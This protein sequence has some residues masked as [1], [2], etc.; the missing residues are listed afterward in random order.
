MTEVLLIIHLFGVILGAG[1]AFASDMMFFSSARDKMFSK[2]EMRFLKIGS[3]MVWTGLIILV[4]SGT[5]L[6]LQ[7]TERYLASSKFL[8]KMTVVAVIFV[9]GIIFHLWHIPRLRRHMDHH[10][11]SSDEF[12]RA[13]P[14]LLASG[15]VSFTSWVFAFVL[16]SLRSIPLTYLQG[17]LL[18]VAA[19]VAAISTAILIRGRVLPHHKG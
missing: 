8:V 9:N 11:P 7:D 12:M 2:T 4:L 10:Y 17:V 5:G 16:G 1:G 13:R 19:L 15:A 14:W 6:F 18:Y 3:M